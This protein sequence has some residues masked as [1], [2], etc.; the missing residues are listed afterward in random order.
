MSGNQAG[1][2]PGRQ[3]LDFAPGLLDIQERLPSPL[4]RMVLRGLLLLL[5]AL[6]LWAA[7]GRLDIVAVAEGKLIPKTY[8]KIVQPAESGI[9]REIAVAEGQHVE[10]GQVLVRMDANIS[11]AD[12]KSIRQA[13][14]HKTL[15]LRRTDAELS[16]LPFVREAGDSPQLFQ[17]IQAAYLSNRRALEDDLAAE[18]AS[19]QRATQELASALEIQ[20]KL[21]ETLPAYQAQEA[22]FEKLGK[23][24]FAGNLMVM[25]KKRERIEKEQ[26]LQAQKYNAMSLQASIAQS[27]RRLA[28]IQS[29]Y[30]QK[31]EAERV[32]IYAEHQRLEQEWAKQ[33]HRNSLLELKAPQAG[34]IK[35]L[36][37]HTPGTVVSPGTVLMTLVP[38]SEQLLAEVWVKNTDAGFVRRGQEVKVKLSAYPFQK[39]G[40]VTGNVLRVSADSTDRSTGN[41]QQTG[42]EAAQPMSAQFSY[43]TLI[44]LKL[45]HLEFDQSKL[46]LAPGM[47]VAAEIKL[48]DQTVLEY[49]LSPVR[50]AFHEAG[51]ER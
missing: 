21:E 43:R 16:G 3:A 51:R 34:I 33:L 9:V 40:M 13:L 44:D 30:R 25:E 1:K 22:S 5:L 17:R 19:R 24:G 38:N 26:D 37:T 36:A 4:P 41:N 35:D 42:A 45:Q 12:S 8:L 49:L 29:D 18:R 10:A 28:Q 27:D 14:E 23:V 50:K 47:Q 15:E 39:Y 6:L 32:A 2:L 31:L 48:T 7:F 46:A 20:R 11:E